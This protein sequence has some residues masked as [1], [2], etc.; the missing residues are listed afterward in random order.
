MKMLQILLRSE[1]FYLFF[2]F[3][4]D[5]K[6]PAAILKSANEISGTF[7]STK[8]KTISKHVRS[9]NIASFTPKIKNTI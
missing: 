9:T 2:N 3:C 5:L 1:I 8:V 6:I 7:S 4:E